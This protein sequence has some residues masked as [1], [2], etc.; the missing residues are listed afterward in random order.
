MGTRPWADAID[1]CAAGV[2][3]GK[4][5]TGWPRG[6]GWC[7]DAKPSCRQGLWRS[8]VDG[9]CVMRETEEA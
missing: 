7:K 6:G 3:E 5:L 4:K 1:G 8:R 2:A 9:E